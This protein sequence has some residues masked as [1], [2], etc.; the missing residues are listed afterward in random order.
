MKAKKLLSVLLAMILAFSCMT[1]LTLTAPLTVSA[2][3]STEKAIFIGNT[4]KIATAF[5]P[6]NLVVTSKTWYELE[7][8]CRM[9]NNGESTT[10]PAL[11]AIGILGQGETEVTTCPDWAGSYNGTNA[12]MTDDNNFQASLSSGVYKMRFYVGTGKWSKSV[13]KVSG[14]G[15]RTVYITVGNAAYRY[16]QGTSS[17]LAMKNFTCSFIFSNVTV[18]QCT[19]ETGSVTGDNLAPAWNAD[20]IDF[21]GTYYFRKDPTDEVDGPISATANKWHVMAMPKYVKSITVPSDYNTA[22]NVYNNPS[23]FKKTEATDYTREYYTNTNYSDLYFAKLDTGNTK[24]FE[25]ISSDLNKKMIVIDA[26]HNGE[27]DNRT[28]DGYEPVYNRP[29]NLF[30]PLSLGQYNMDYSG[31]TTDTSYLVKVSF[32]AVRLEG[33]GYPVLGRITARDT[34]HSQAL[35]KM[36]KNLHLSGYYSAGDHETYTGCNYTYNETTGEFVGWTRMKAGDTSYRS[37]YGTSEILTIGNA[38]H[39]YR[40]GNTSAMFDT[41]EFNTSFAISNIKVDLYSTTHPADSVY[42]PDSLIAEDIAPGLY[43]DTVDTNSQ[44]AYQCYNYSTQYSAHSRDVARAKSEFWQAEGNVGM[45]HTMD[46]TAC[47]KGNHVGNMTHH[48]ATETTREYWGCATC[49]K[50]YADPY[51]KEQITDT[52]ATNQ[53]VVLQA[54]GSGNETIVYPLTLTNF[55]GNQWFKFTCKVKCYGDDYPTVS[56]FYGNYYGLN[57][58]ETTKPGDD[59]GVKEYSYDEST[60]ILTAYLF[61]WV[62]DIINRDNRY[63]Y[64]RINP[65]SGANCAIVVGNGRWVNTGYTDAKYTSSFAITDPVLK[66]LD[67][68]TSGEINKDKL[69]SALADAKSKS[70]T[71]DNLVKPMTS[72]TVDFNSSYSSNYED[73]NNVMTAPIGKWYKI[74]SEASMITAREIPQGVFSGTPNTKML[75]FS[76]PKGNP[77]ENVVIANYQTYIKSNTTYQFDMDYSIFGGAKPRILIQTA[78]GSSFETVQEAED[79]VNGN[80]ITCEFTTGTLRTN[81]VN[82]RVQMGASYDSGNN[83]M[84]IYFTNLSLRKK[85]GTTLYGNHLINGDLSFAPTEYVYNTDMADSVIKESIPYWDAGSADRGASVIGA[86]KSDRNY[87]NVYLLAYS[88]RV[89]EEDS[90]GEIKGRQDIAVKMTGHASHGS[91]LQFLAGLE[92]SKRYELTFNYRTNGDVPELVVSKTLDGVSDPTIVSKDIWPRYGKYA[93]RYVI[94]TPSAYRRITNDVATEYWPNASSNANTRFR[95]KFGGWSAGKDIYVNAVTLYELDGSGNHVGGNIAGELNALL[96]AGIYDTVVPNVGDEYQVLLNQDGTNNI[97]RPVA[98]GWFGVNQANDYSQFNGA[99]VKVPTDFFDRTSYK[100]RLSTLRKAIIG[101]KATDSLNPDYN[102][103]DD[104]TI[105]DVKDLVHMK[106]KAVNYD[107]GGDGGGAEAEANYRI[108][109]VIDVKDDSSGDVPGGTSY[110]VSYSE[111]NDSSN[112]G[113]SASAPFKTLNKANSKASAG[114]TIYLKRG[115]TWRNTD[116]TADYAFTFK[117]G[118]NYAAYGTG[119]KPVLSGSAKDYASS[120]LWTSAGTNIWKCQYNSGTKTTNANAGMIYFFDSSGKIY[121]GKH[122]ACSTSGAADFT[123]SNLDS[124]LE[125]FAPYKSGTSN[126]LTTGSYTSQ[127]YIYVYSTTNPGSRFSHIEIATD[128]RGVVEAKSGTSAKIT[129]INNIAIMFGGIHGVKGTSGGSHVHLEKCEIAYIGG[130]WTYEVD[131]TTG[132]GKWNRLGNGVE[133]GDGYTDGRVL[134]CYIHDCYDAGATFQSYHE[135]SSGYTFSYMYFN[136]NVIDRCSYSIEFFTHNNTDR[137]WSIG[138]SNNIL[139]NAGYGWAG[140]QRVDNGWRVANICGSKNNYMNITTEGS[141]NAKFKIQNNIFDC[142]SNAHVVWYWQ[143]QHGPAKHAN[144]EVNGNTYFQRCGGLGDID[145][146]RAMNYGSMINDDNTDKGNAMRY[147]YSAGDLATAVAAFDDAPAGVYWVDNNY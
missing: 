14:T 61:G 136:N 83:Q 17:V 111:G 132:V 113:I 34:D 76:G 60:G 89:F 129:K 21:A 101:F 124:D 90:D 98:V 139:R 40:G 146:P 87:N 57:K 134:N 81:K 99:I 45:V 80:H 50:S 35:G 109:N 121:Y 116:L 54:S 2:A 51:G 62:K 12:V 27:A 70:V 30:I 41:T 104:G 138:F 96:G 37:V 73:S 39:V 63:P 46:L 92:Q 33:D 20:N 68:A 112:N 72:A 31:V 147:A 69:D 15:S 9:L 91:Q 77:S 66:K 137:M 105:A 11:P 97:N 93:V 119:D 125:F 142:T 108:K 85:V 143:S 110:Y 128:H 52:S 100:T 131:K 123:A 18:K 6:L 59:F 133:F 74:G 88:P 117:A 86:I 114:D 78:S 43:A 75:R 64:E 13:E 36:A 103:N 79:T 122:M 145:S 19:S 49:K 28:I 144:L 47:M 102:P 3:T 23:T 32:K 94:E 22:T 95:I 141:G 16:P 7:F 29:A 55:E 82:F 10:M 140:N 24:G 1:V 106:M 8:K 5:L 42:T 4:D 84:T 115:D 25:V 127:G 56:A 44:W 118:V 130:G 71:G 38:E 65:I 126:T 67:G 120:S 48:A 58:Y 26:N 53:M 107:G 135:S